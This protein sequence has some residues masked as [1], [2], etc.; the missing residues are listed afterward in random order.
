MTVIL[1]AGLEGDIGVSKVCVGIVVPLG[2]NISTLWIPFV[3]SGWL[4][5]PECGIISFL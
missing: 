2:T 3:M 4:T 5:S 1:S